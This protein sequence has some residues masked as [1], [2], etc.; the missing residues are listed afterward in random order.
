MQEFILDLIKEK[1][2]IKGIIQAGANLGQECPYF[3]RYTSNIICFEPIPSV[4]NVLKNNNPDISC[5]NIALG[6]VNEIRSMNIA[7]NEGQSSSFLDPLHHINEF[8]DIK[9]ISNLN[10]EIKRFDS[11]DINI[12]NFNVLISDT[13][14]YEINVLKGFGKKLKSIDAIYVEYCNELY[15]GDSNLDSISRYLKDY[16]FELIESYPESDF[17]GNALFLKK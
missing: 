16:D 14:G 3:R 4:F 7:S 15:V 12:E 5:Y 13:Q 8:K 6:D 10:L 11:L 1:F 17:W 2:E 9:F